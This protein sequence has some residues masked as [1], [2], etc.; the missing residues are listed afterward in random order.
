MEDPADD[1]DG[2]DKLA[3]AIDETKKYYQ[4]NPDLAGCYINLEADN[5][6]CLCCN[7]ML[8]KSVFDV[9]QKCSTYKNKHYLIH[10][11]VA[12]AIKALYDGQ[13]PPRRQVQ[14]PHKE[15]QPNRVSAAS[16]SRHKG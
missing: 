13:D 10:W 11:G 6:H 14:R 15:T 3:I 2:D 9:Y 7:K 4:D 5:V 8:G 16:R 12:T 1:S